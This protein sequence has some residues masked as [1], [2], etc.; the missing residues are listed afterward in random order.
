MSSSAANFGINIIINLVGKPLGR[1]LWIGSNFWIARQLGPVAFG[2][3]TLGYTIFQL[4]SLVGNAG[5]NSAILKYSV[6]FEQ[7]QRRFTSFFFQVFKLNLIVNVFL[8]C[9]L[10]FLADVIARFSFNDPLLADPLKVLA[11]A[12]PLFQILNTN[13]TFLKTHGNMA[14]AVFSQDL[15]SPLFLLCCV[16]IAIILGDSVSP[17]IISYW[18]LISYIIGLV[19]SS[20]FLTIKF[21]FLRRPCSKFKSITFSEILSYSLPTAFSG[22]IVTMMY[23][24]DKLMLGLLGTSEDIGFYQSAVQISMFYLIVANAFNTAITPSVS[25]FQKHRDKRELEMLYTI[26]SR[27]I[28]SLSLIL[29][30]TVVCFPKA[31]IGILFGTAYS[32]SSVALVILSIGQ[33]VN[34]TAGAGSILLIMLGYQRAWLS[35]NVVWLLINLLLNTALIPQFGFTG[36]AVSTALSVSGMFVVCVLTVKR[37]IKIWPYDKSFLKPIIASLL[38]GLLL[39]LLKTVYQPQTILAMLTVVF[40]AF[41]LMIGILFLMRFEKH[42]VEFISKF[43]GSIIGKHHQ[44]I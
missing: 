3:F 42:D 2:V 11:I 4:T 41:I 27:W 16:V 13:S 5:L 30:V 44:N 20:I 24:L 39:F 15:I 35:I 9:L 29:F 1:L 25:K 8:C 33:L 23:W 43:F 38:I 34:A 32:Q 6:H 17:L 36:A 26:S 21:P 40:V 10:F 7:S 19:A 22:L 28:M 18:L 37:R 14:S 31:F 12:I